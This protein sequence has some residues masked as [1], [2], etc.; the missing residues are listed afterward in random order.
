MDVVGQPHKLGAKAC[1]YVMID[2]PMTRPTLNR[3]QKSDVWTWLKKHSNKIIWNQSVQHKR[4][5]YLTFWYLGESILRQGHNPTNI[6]IMKILGFRNRN[7]LFVIKV[8]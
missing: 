3:L 1:Y 6:R 2:A 7:F 8:T 4:V 5:R